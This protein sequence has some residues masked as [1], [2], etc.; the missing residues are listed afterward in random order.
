MLMIHLNGCGTANDE[1]ERKRQEEEGGEIDRKVR[2]RAPTRR[3]IWDA[4]ICSPLPSPDPT[5]LLRGFKWSF[6]HPAGYDYMDS[7]SVN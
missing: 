4:Y 3:G 1:T 2:R 7:L 5:L 6:N